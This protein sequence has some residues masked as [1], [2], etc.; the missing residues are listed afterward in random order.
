MNKCSHGAEILKELGNHNIK[1]KTIIMERR[2]QTIKR[3]IKRIYK[4]IFGRWWEKDS[5]YTQFASVVYVKDFNGNDCENILTS[6][7]H[8]YIVLG[9]TKILKKNILAIPKYFVLNGH[10]GWLPDY[11]GMDVIPWAILTEGRFGITI[12]IVDEGID[13][14]MILNRKR[15]IISKDDTLE[16]LATKAEKLI[17]KEMAITLLKLENDNATFTPNTGGKYWNTMTPEQKEAVRCKLKELQK[18]VE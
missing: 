14:G 11:R 3:R 4:N 12:H 8:D 10:P 7:N 18:V 16:S 13:S 15:M 17:A 6:I 5:F 9:G 2:P 1:P